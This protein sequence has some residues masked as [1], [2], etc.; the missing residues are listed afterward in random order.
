M[1]E[2][3]AERVAIS[4]SCQGANKAITKS[5]TAELQ[6]VARSMGEAHA[7]RVAID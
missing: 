5:S 1:G 3:H 4:E 2:A 6:Q 7:G